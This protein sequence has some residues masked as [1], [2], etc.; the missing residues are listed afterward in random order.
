MEILERFQNMIRK[1]III[2]S[3]RY[4]IGNF[5]GNVI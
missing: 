3:L 4:R 1:G 2:C 5:I